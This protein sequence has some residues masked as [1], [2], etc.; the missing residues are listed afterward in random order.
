MTI[1]EHSYHTL[2]LS[3]ILFLTAATLTQAILLPLLLSVF[4]VS[5]Q[6]YWRVRC[7]SHGST[8]GRRAATPF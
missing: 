3:L 5:M 7:S 6:P 2:E 1:L 8:A 4:V